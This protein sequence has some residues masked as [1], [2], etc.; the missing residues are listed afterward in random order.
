MRRA[1][2]D[3]LDRRFACT[4][5][6]SDVVVGNGHVRLI[7]RGPGEA[8]DGEGAETE[9]GA[10]APAKPKL[11]PDLSKQALQRLQPLFGHSF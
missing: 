4:E 7:I 5:T 11:V 3:A 2:L 10:G 9:D 8:G 6:L 1:I